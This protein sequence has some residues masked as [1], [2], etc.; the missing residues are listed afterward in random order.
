MKRLYPS[1]LQTYLASNTNNYVVDLF[2]ITLPNGQVINATS[3]QFGITVPSGTPGWVNGSGA[4]L[5]T[6]TFHATDYG[7]WSRGSITLEAGF[8][9]KSNTME[10]TCE[11]GS[12]NINYPGLSLPILNASL[13]GLFDFAAVSVWTAY[14]PIGNYGN[15]GHGIETKFFGEIA[16]T[17]ELDSKHVT[18]EVAD[19]F[20]LL[21]LK[22][23]SRTFRPDSPWMP[24]DVNFGM[25][26]TGTDIN[27]YQMTQA[28]TAAAGST[29]WS[30]T[31]ATRF[32]QPAGYFTQGVVTCTGGANEGLSQTVK[33][34]ASGVL[35]LMN[36]WLI[37]PS[38]GDT[39][40]VVVGYD[41]TY[42]TLVEKFGNGINFGGTPFVPPATQTV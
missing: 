34:H 4:S 16:K 38:V 12:N 13:N 41:G 39:F 26:V 20:Y 40:S 31:P 29:M 5:P 17:N 37:T 18:F 11:P 1:Q 28:F 10:L 2:Q 9:L 24:G 3:G 15:V 36:P 35:T 42:T 8:D 30:L 7:I 14:M 19:P 27:G 33:L 32:A 6:T 23:P 22:I 21:N 25:S